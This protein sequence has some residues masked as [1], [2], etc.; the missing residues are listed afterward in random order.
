MKIIT[1]KEMIGIEDEKKALLEKNKG[2]EAEVA[3][4]KEM[5]K[6]IMEQQAEYNANIAALKADNAKAVSD[7]QS[8]TE[9]LK[10]E[11]Q[12]AINELVAVH[13]KTISDMS[14]KVQ[15]AEA[16]SEAKAI[17]TLATIGVPA[18]ELPK[19]TTQNNTQVLEEA[20]K[21]QGSQLSEYFEQNKKAIFDALKEANKKI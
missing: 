13:E 19:V 5:S 9:V 15:L 11:H 1:R 3:S 10:A 4:L 2:L 12:K 18:E 20:K 14:A 7:L 8:A 21:L 6:D 16:S 17:K